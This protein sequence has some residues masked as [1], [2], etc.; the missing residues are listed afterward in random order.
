MAVFGLFG[1]LVAAERK[2][3]VVKEIYPVTGSSFWCR[4]PCRKKGFISYQQI[5]NVGEK[6]SI[7]YV[8]R[9]VVQWI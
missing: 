5:D 8:L 6:H 3:V 2:Y 4:I 7:L 9:Y 1:L